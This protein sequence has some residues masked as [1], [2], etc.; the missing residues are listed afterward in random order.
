[1]RVL[2]KIFIYLQAQDLSFA[3]VVAFAM[4]FC[5]STVVQGQK[6]VSF[7]PEAN[8]TSPRPERIQEQ[9]ENRLMPSV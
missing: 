2:H 3:F 8:P 6:A 7:L 1:M 5:S 4:L 9:T